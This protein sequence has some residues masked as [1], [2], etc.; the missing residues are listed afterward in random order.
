MTAASNTKIGSPSSSDIR[1]AHVK[2]HYGQ[3]MGHIAQFCDKKKTDGLRESN[4]ASS[5]AEEGKGVK[6]LRQR[7]KVGR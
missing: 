4:S 1:F 3:R 7:R 6:N 5:N 2:L